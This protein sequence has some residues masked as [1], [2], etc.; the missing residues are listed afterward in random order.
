MWLVGCCGYAITRVLW[1]V[2]NVLLCGCEG[3]VQ[4][5]KSIALLLLG[6]HGWLPVCCC[7]VARVSW[8]VNRELLCDC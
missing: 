8:V 5:S 4:G 3:V 6:C 7:M 2:A 1:G